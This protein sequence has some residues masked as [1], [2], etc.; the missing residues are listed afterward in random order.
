MHDAVCELVKPQACVFS[1]VS[2]SQHALA[3]RLVAYQCGRHKKWHFEP[4]AFA[5]KI[6]PSMTLPNSS[7]R[8]SILRSVRATLGEGNRET[9]N[10]E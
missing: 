4:N 1:K 9:E 7:L 3:C 10:R 6:S 2:D 8:L 5:W